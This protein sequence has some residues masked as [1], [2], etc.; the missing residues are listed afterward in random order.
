MTQLFVPEELRQGVAA[1][2]QANGLPWQV[3]DSEPFDIRVESGTGDEPL[4][5]G[6]DVLEAGGWI[7]CATAWG[8]AKKH[9]IPLGMLG[10][11]LDELKIKVRH[12]SLGCF[13]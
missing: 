6:V 3:V 7:K 13:D 9:G 11:L 4:Q 8:L 12:C 1:F 5:C 10:K 2:I